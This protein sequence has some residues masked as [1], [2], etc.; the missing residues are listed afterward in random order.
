[1]HQLAVEQTIASEA[2]LGL[3]E[4]N[5]DLQQ[6]ANRLHAEALA[7]QK[8]A[9]EKLSSISSELNTTNEV[10]QEISEEAKDQNSA[11]HSIDMRASETNRLL[12]EQNGI[13]RLVRRSV[14]QLRIDQA[15]QSFAQWR[16]TPDG[17]K[18]MQW[19]ES[20]NYLASI[21]RDYT[22]RLADAQITDAQ[23]HLIKEIAVHRKPDAEKI[24]AQFYAQ[25]PPKPLE[26]TEPEPIVADLNVN[27]D[28]YEK[29]SKAVV[30]VL[31]VV[32]II[33]A[34]KIIVGPINFFGTLLCLLVLGGA[35]LFI[36]SMVFDGFAK[37][38]KNDKNA[39]LEKQSREFTAHLEWQQR[40]DA[41]EA[42]LERWKGERSEII[43]N[44]DYVADDQAPA[45]FLKKCKQ[46]AMSKTAPPTAWAVT[47]P[48]PLLKQITTIMD[49]AMFRPPAPDQL[50]DLKFP[51]FVKLED[52]PATAPHMRAAFAQILKEAGQG[53]PAIES[54]EK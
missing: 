3:Q 6:E 27:Q 1:M 24:R 41:A 53:Q 13:I 15:Y 51:G 33:I 16:Q 42:A 52:I 17:R 25:I 48:Q 45:D 47:D 32:E 31:A 38:Y 28:D 49:N 18:Y 44:A 50:P 7:Q 34:L 22:Q 36:A 2:Q 12:Q 4:I 35:S 29:R 26:F 54:A 40:K 46:I 9:N 43:Y 5:A 30:T 20:A 8:Q 19:S 10:L 23:D 14:N 37:K 11:L 39:A 21:I